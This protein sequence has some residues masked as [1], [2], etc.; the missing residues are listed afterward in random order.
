MQRKN[1][2]RTTLNQ[3]NN[4]SDELKAKIKACKNDDEML[5]L[6]SAEKIELDPEM[7]SAVSGGNLRSRDDCPTVLR[8]SLVSILRNVGFFA[9]ATLHESWI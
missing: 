9:R 3:I 8:D 2:K 1:R 4:L 7:M 5:S 6:L